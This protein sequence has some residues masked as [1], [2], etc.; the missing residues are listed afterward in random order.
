LLIGFKVETSL[1]TVLRDVS[2]DS[3][4]PLGFPK[5]R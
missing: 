5:R 1:S 3:L 4:S 2:L